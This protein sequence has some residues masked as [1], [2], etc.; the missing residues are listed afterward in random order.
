[1]ADH[2][3]LK[4]R[5]VRLIRGLALLPCL[6]ALAVPAWPAGPF[7]SVSI[8]EFLADNRR[9]LRDNEG[10][11][12]GWIELANSGPD[13]VDLA[14]WSLSNSPTNLTKWRFPAVGLLPGSSLVVFA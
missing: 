7:S 10:D 8:S 6:L 5:A 11:Y 1:M 14:G 2:C 12:S 13:P 3:A 9:T 4:N